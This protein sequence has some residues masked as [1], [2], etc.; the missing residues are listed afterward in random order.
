MGGMAMYCMKCGR[1]IT[2]DQVFC[3]KCLETMERYPV[4]P[5][6]VVQLPQR[7]ETSLKK[8]APRKKVLTAEEQILR[9]KK[10]NRLLTAILCLV[11]ITAA[12]LFSITIDYFR[13]MD[14]QKILGQN[15]ST[16]ETTD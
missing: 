13:H 7:R 9:L 10:K 2:G 14:V 15:Y 8:S 3:P 1:E 4:K 6:V 12:F 16:M 11:L 5:D